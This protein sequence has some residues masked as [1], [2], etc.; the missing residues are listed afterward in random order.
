MWHSHAWMWFCVSIPM[1][2]SSLSFTHNVLHA[3][4]FFPWV[5]SCRFL[6]LC[7][8][9]TST[10]LISQFLLLSFGIPKWLRSEKKERKG[11]RKLFLSATPYRLGKLYRNHH[12]EIVHRLPRLIKNFLLVNRQGSNL[13]SVRRNSFSLPFH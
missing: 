12:F 5:A 7:S 6:S 10:L 13:V 3:I 1:Y 11:C 2:S 9:S 8:T 4:L